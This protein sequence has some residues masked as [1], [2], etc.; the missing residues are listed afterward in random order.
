MTLTPVV[1]TRDSQTIADLIS[2]RDVFRDG[3]DTIELQND[4]SISAPTTNILTSL[5]RRVLIV[6]R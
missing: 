3:R 2:V 4:P 6:L 1:N 5:N